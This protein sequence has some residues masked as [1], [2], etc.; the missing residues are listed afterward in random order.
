M[1]NPVSSNSSSSTSA[2]NSQSSVSSSTSELL[3]SFKD[4]MSTM[5]L[6]GGTSGESSSGIGDMMGPLMMLILLDKLV[7]GGLD[8]G[9]STGTAAEAGSATQAATSSQSGASSN[10]EAKPIPSGVPVK[11]ILT[12][13]SHTGHTALDLAVPVGTSVQSTMDGQVVYAGWNNQGY[14]NLVIVQNGEYKTYY[15]HLSSVPVA[16]GDSVKAGSTIGISGSTGNSTGPHVH[17]EIRKNNVAIDPTSMS[18]G[19]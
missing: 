15:A 4:I 12:Q 10:G 7:E 1:I 19:A 18:L 8:L 5:M 9:D 3:S 13:G 17:Y 14:G 2:T 11:G 16:V 6:S